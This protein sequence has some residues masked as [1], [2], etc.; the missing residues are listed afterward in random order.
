MPEQVRT[1]GVGPGGDRQSV[2]GRA[3]DGDPAA[4]DPKVP[5]TDGTPGSN[6]QTYGAVIVLPS[7]SDV[8]NDPAARLLAGASENMSADVIAAAL[9]LMQPT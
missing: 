7:T 8:V 3:F 4:V 1:V 9:F 2:R 5:R 6:V